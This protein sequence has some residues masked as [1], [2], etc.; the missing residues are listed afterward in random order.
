MDIAYS[1]ADY[2][3]TKED[4]AALFVAGSDGGI[5]LAPLFVCAALLLTMN[6]PILIVLHHDF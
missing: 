3:G 5:Y 1:D 6:F 2:F 4:R